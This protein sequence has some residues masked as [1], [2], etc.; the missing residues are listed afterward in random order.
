MLLRSADLL[1]AGFLSGS[2]PTLN[3]GNCDGW[4]GPVYRPKRGSGS[5]VSG[6]VAS[7]LPLGSLKVL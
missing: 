5:G 7:P 4:N 3:A 2:L 6:G 1:S